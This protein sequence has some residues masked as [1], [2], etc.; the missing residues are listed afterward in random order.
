MENNLFNQSL[1]RKYS[2]HFNPTHKQKEIIRGYVGQVENNTFKA[3]TRGYLKFYD[4]ILKG[5]L[6][7]TTLDVGFDE[8]V[9]TGTGRSEFIL[10]SGDKKFM[11]VELKGQG[12]DLDK[13]QHVGMI[14]VHR[15]I[16]LLAIY[17][18]GIWNGSSSPTTMNLGS[19]IIMRKLNTYH[20]IMPIYHSTIRSYLM[21]NTIT[22]IKINVNPPYVVRVM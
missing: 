21:S 17:T 11:V 12:I 5:L 8:K 9:D 18:Q 7:Y 19:I 13:K 20:L 4:L 6:G 22:I 2:H 14:P 15:L 16:R 10:K 1:L 3:E